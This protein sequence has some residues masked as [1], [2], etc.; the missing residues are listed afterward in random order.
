MT[1]STQEESKK[2]IKRNPLKFLLRFLIG[3]LL[4]ILLLPVLIHF[5]PIQKFI[6]NRISNQ[7]TDKTKSHI[8]I[9]RVDFSFFKGLQLEELYISNPDNQSDTLI[10]IGSMSSSLKENL[11]S[12]IDNELQLEKINISDLSLFI[13][14][15]SIENISN[16]DS[17]LNSLRSDSE[18]PKPSDHI[19]IKLREIVLDQISIQIIDEKKLE[20]FNVNLDQALVELKDFSSTSDTIILSKLMLSNPKVRIEIQKG[21][22]NIVVKDSIALPEEIIIDSTSSPVY[23]FVEHLELSGGEFYLDDWNFEELIS[24]EEFID[25]KH[26]SITNFN[27]NADSTDISFPFAINSNIK[28]LTLKE[29]QGFEIQQLDVKSLYFS[30][31]RLSLND[32]LLKTG[33]SSL[34]DHL[35]FNFNGFEDFKSFAQN[36]KLN[37]ELNDSKIAFSDLAYFFLELY[38]S[39]F[40]RLNKN[41]WI[42]ISGE[43]EGTVDE[44]EAD[45]LSLSINNQIILRGTLSTNDLTNSSSA[46]VNLYV[47]ELST[48]LAGLRRIIPDFRPPEQFYKL[49]PITFS[50]DID[51]F[52]NDFVIYGY[53]KSDLGRVTLDT[54]LNITEGI[55]DARYSGEIAL[56]DFDLNRWTDNENLG[57]AT[58]T[59]RINDGRGLTLE[60]VY[61][62]LT[63]SLEKFEFKSYNYSNVTLEGELQKNLFNGK[64]V[65]LDPNIDFDFDGQIDISKNQFKTDFEA[66]IRKIDLNAINLSNDFSTIN[67]KFN[68]S[69]SGTGT[70]DFEGFVDIEGMALNYK[71]KPFD[72]DSLY[73][74]SSPAEEGNR[75]LIVSS[76]VI[77]GSVSG[78]FDF[79]ELVPNFSNFLN[80]NHPAW[81]KRLNIK[82][83]ELELNNEQK[84]RFKIQISDT[85]DYLELLNVNDLRLKGLTFEGAPNLKIGVLNSQINIDSFLYKDYSFKSLSLGL[86]HSNQLSKYT[87]LLDKFYN[88][89]KSFD[90]VEVRMDINGDIV[91]FHVTT[92]NVLDSIGDIDLS[93][94]VVPD[95]DKLVFKLIERNLQMFSSDWNV[96]PDNEIIYGDNYIKVNDFVISDGYREIEINDY[97]NLG[98]RTSLKN[99]DFQLINGIINYDKIDFTGEGDADIRIDNIFQEPEVYASVFIPEFKLNNVDYGALIVNAVSDSSDF[100]KA[101]INLNREEDDLSLIVNAD[102]NKTNNE[103]SGDVLARNMVM[104]TFQFILED[105]ISNTDGVANIDAKISGTADDIKLR[106]EARIVDGITTINY[107]GSELRLGTEKIRVSENFIDLTNVSLY[108]KFG[109]RATMLG[110][111]RH[112]L[113]ADFRSQLTI[114]SDRFLA[115]DTEKEDNP[116]YYGSGIG[117]LSV[118]FSGPF[119][120]T[121]ID[122]TAV[123]GAGTVLN[124]PVEDTYEN[125]DESFIKFV[126]RDLVLNPNTDSVVLN[127]KLEGV[128]VQM[129]LSITQDAQVNII[130]NERL[131]DI[132]KGRGNGDLRIIVSR[133]GDFNIFGSYE[134]ESGDYL[135]TAWGIV[136]KP[137]EVKRGGLITWTGDPINANLNIETTYSGLRAPTNV[138]LDEYLVTASPAIQIEAKKRTSVDLTMRLTGTLYK[139]DVNFDLSFPELQGE[140]RTYADNKVRTL[141]EN[142]ADLN[143]QV[144]GLIMFRSFLPSNSLGDNLLTGGSLA[145]TS[146]NTLSEFISN[147]LSYL[148]SGFLQEALAE[149]GFVSGIDFVIEFS[150]NDDLEEGNVN[151]DR[152]IPDEIEVHFKP[153]FQNDKWGFDYGTSFVNST[154]QGITNYFIHDFVLEYYLTDDRRL[155]L[156]A[157]GKWD[158]DEVESENEQK[159]GLGINFRKEFGRITQFKKSLSKDISKLNE[160]ENQIL[161]ILDLIK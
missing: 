66:E 67:G 136:A 101:D 2:I 10:Y 73:I 114:N 15:D 122:V 38:D 91:D 104:S 4:L 34:S 129:N 30:E 150:R 36:I 69:V 72:F 132:I 161:L 102:Y 128:D 64:I 11:T 32:F 139:P 63:A 9:G 78:K 88:K 35:E 42:Q 106:G 92:K 13:K 19:D 157:Y 16:L 149:N 43:I 81:A 96:S 18:E 76:N 121:D 145:Q 100:I 142:E 7:V 140:L 138:F 20:K 55:G 112:D 24:E 97:H 125:F 51:G 70:K 103:V 98:V 94:K 82:K 27:I 56:Q 117:Q 77:N 120:S 141:R 124:I 109:N 28:S 89:S 75:N 137:F 50:G 113:F 143:E 37:T 79:A 65:A 80:K 83:S 135:F 58:L 23:V 53:L 62:D 14:K 154:I 159:Y 158:K 115:L 8:E 111:L 84:F 144:A 160:E 123:T 110:G 99:F 107:L 17:F 22:K 119:S 147:Q 108:D 61:T 47:D 54:R 118:E 59:A 127:T 44:I 45:N 95:D 133:E 86:L 48:S 3:L 33:A 105:G 6:L 52:F 60:S 49:G 74:S 68:C 1:E 126:D 41:R 156:R 12:L 39:P 31:E 5:G 134:V 46:L 153:R 29:K 151:V 155:K 90:P 26:L 40:F 130:F 85:K 21:Q 93:L 71:E 146:Y 148:L 25:Y 152:L 87:L 57:L 131:N 116:L